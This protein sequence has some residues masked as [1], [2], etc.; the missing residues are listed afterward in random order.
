MLK[1]VDIVD[2]RGNRI[3]ETRINFEGMAEGVGNYTESVAG[4][5]TMVFETSLELKGQYD[6][7]KNF[8]ETMKLFKGINDNFDAKVDEMEF[9]VSYAKT[10]FYLT[11]KILFF[12]AICLLI[13]IPIGGI[14]ALIILI[15]SP[16][17]AVFASSYY[18]SKREKELNKIK[19]QM[20]DLYS[21]YNELIE[22]FKY[23]E[24]DEQ[25]ATKSKE[26]RN[27]LKSEAFARIINEHSDPNW[28]FDKEKIIAS[29]PKNFMGEM[30]KFFLVSLSISVITGVIAHY[31][32]IEIFK[33]SFSQQ[34][35]WKYSNNVQGVLAMFLAVA[36]GVWT[37]TV[38]LMQKGKF[39]TKSL[40]KSSFVLIAAILIIF[41][42][43][44]TKTYYGREGLSSEYADKTDYQEYVKAIEKQ[45][46]S[47]KKTKARYK[48]SFEHYV[49]TSLIPGLVHQNSWTSQRA[50]EECKRSENSM[51]LPSF[52][53]LNG[54]VKNG[55]SLEY[56]LVKYKIYGIPSGDIVANDLRN[57]VNNLKGFD[58]GHSKVLAKFIKTYVNKDVIAHLD[59]SELQSQLKQYKQIPALNEFNKQI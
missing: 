40:F 59:I 57:I 43:F 9:R 46:E 30:V 55:K 16:L 11:K 48:T 44:I 56:V 5:A 3:Q 34:F 6:S 14:G 28:S 21:I 52:I 53:D 54:C 50:L 58:R 49:E 1:N 39:S 13:A 26:N 29:L 32:L 7:L 38:Y 27:R 42:G 23:Y 36:I 17:F 15:L 22:S 51:P 24:I 37:F 41:S 33:S 19:D 35:F 25:V 8:V 10:N 31:G 12:L 47:D 4:L 20:S 18:A 45:K 2:S